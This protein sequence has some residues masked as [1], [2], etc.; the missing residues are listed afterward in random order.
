[1]LHSRGVLAIIPARGGSKRILKKNVALL[2]GRPLVAWTIAA[3][4]KS[5]YIDQILVST[6][7]PDVA[8]VA[9]RMGVRVPFMRPHQLA[10][11]ETPTAAVILDALERLTERAH[12]NCDYL[13]ILQPTSPLRRAQDIDQALELIASD[14]VDSVVSVVRLNFPVEW[15]A[16]LDANGRMTKFFKDKPMRSQEYPARYRPNGAIYRAKIA[17]YVRSKGI[18]YGDRCVPY[19]MP[20][21]ASIDIDEPDQ[22][23]IAECL[24]QHINELSALHG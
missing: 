20:E 4:L 22:L 17:S 7:D 15:A 18:L 10:Q 13:T 19:V 9:E 12:Q 11:D 24:M 21:W 14:S 2:A 16:E 1:M 6:D 23:P 3:A 5:K 8:A